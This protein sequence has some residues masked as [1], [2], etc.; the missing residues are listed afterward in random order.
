MA[1]P[2]FSVAQTPRFQTYLGPVKYSNMPPTV[3]PV[4]RWWNQRVVM[5]GIRHPGFRDV[6]AAAVDCD[7]EH[8][9]TFPDDFLWGVA[10]AGHQAEGD[11]TDSDTWFA[12]QVT[13]T[14]FQEPSGKACNGYELWREDVDLA[15]GDGPQRLPLLRGVGAGRADRGHLLRRGA[16]PLRGD[17]RRAA[18]S[19]G[20]APVVTFNH[21]TSPHW[22]AKRGGWLDPEAPP[23]FARYCDTVMERFGDR[24]ASPSP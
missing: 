2:L 21:F 13:P 6:A 9:S 5:R 11:N 10:A 23:L 15:A 8:S 1:P 4:T 3:P 18:S 16:R 17:R 7:G 20:M 12:E 22:F 14:V 19:A 24:I